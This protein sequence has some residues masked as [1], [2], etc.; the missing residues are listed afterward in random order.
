MLAIWVLSFLLAAPGRSGEPLEA[1]AARS[2]RDAAAASACRRQRYSGTA[3]SGPARRPVI[4]PSSTFATQL[5]G[6]PGI[7]VARASPADE[8]PPAN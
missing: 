8:A 2:S 4:G 3:P 7:D 5:S 1:G 6:A